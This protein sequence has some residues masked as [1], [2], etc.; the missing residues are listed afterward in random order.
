V[1]IKLA[2]GKARAIQHMA[3]TT[4]WHPDGTPMSAQ[5]FMELLFGQLPEFFQNEAELRE[6][7]S[8]P[9]TRAK[10]LAGLA[11]KG[12]GREQLAEMQCIISAEKSDLFDVLAHVAYALPPLTREQRASKA[13]VELT[14]HFNSKQRVFLEFVLSHYVL[15]GVEELDQ[16]KLTPLLRLKY[17]DSLADAIEDLGNPLEIGRAFADFQKYLYASAS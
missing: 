11:E 7:W 4:F 12:F 17:R 15:A 6:L 14:P 10:L 9:E 5:Q 13:K 8:S 2:D 3:M 1:K 16:E